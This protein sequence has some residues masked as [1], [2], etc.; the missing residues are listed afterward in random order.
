MSHG[1]VRVNAQST[2]KVISRRLNLWKNLLTMGSEQRDT[3]RSSMSHVLV[4]VN[5]QSTAKVISRR[6]NLWKNLLTMG[7]EQKDTGRSSMSHELV[8]VNAQSTAKVTKPLEESVDHGISSLSAV[9]EMW[10]VP[11]VG[12]LVCFIA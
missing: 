1:L 10:A 4:R 11:Y 2:A 9:Q 3:G 7:S 5:A 6:L 8:R 12:V